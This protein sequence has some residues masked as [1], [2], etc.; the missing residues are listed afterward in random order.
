MKK[1]VYL[2]RY[3]ESRGGWLAYVGYEHADKCTLVVEVD[4][5]KRDSQ[6]AKNKA[7]TAANNNFEGVKI[8]K[9]HDNDPMWGLSNFPELEKIVKEIKS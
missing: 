8:V 7:I 6:K 5:D 1:K 3:P 2:F 4:I 9:T